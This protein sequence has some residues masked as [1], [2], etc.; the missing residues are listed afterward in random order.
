MAGLSIQQQP[1]TYQP[2]YNDLI[3]VLTS[4]NSS[5]SNYKYILDI[6]VSVD[7]IR[8]KCFPDPVYGSGV[9]NIGRI[10]ETYVGSDIRKDRYDFKTNDNS[11]IRYSVSGGEEYGDDGEVVVYAGL[12]TTETIYAWNAVVKYLP[13]QSYA[14][15]NYLSDG[16]KV[17]NFYSSTFKRKIEFNQD[18]WVYFNQSDLTMF[19]KAEVTVYNSANAVIRQ[20]DIA[21][22]YSSGVTDASHFTRFSC[23]TRQLNLASSG[24]ITNL[25]GSG[26]I[27][28][29]SAA[30]YSFFFD[31]NNSSQG[32]EFTI[33]DP[34]CTYTTYRLH[35]L[36]KLGAFESFNFTKKPTTET[37]II[38]N[39]YKPPIGAL[40]GANSYSY[41]IKDR[42]TKSFFTQMD[43][44]L[45]LR[46]DWLTDEEYNFLQEL[47]ESPEIYID[48]LTQDGVSYEL[49]PVT[50]ADS[51]FVTKTTLNDKCFALEIN[52]E[53]CFSRFSQRQ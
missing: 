16:G 19:D 39:K 26:A 50:C 10:I 30:R 42:G 12:E 44:A 51:R 2:A 47:I 45:R 11:F 3:F 32:F 52:L 28:T 27:I 53:F 33:I 15:N 24:V 35:W 34:D 48:T 25:V 14:Q 38:R 29:A 8:L 5:N 6:T 37:S 13:F 23:G 31:G 41:A 18:A 43:D 9:F 7:V 1:Q 36:N 4:P 49:V 21:N 40:T 17:L 22:I 20:C 46:T